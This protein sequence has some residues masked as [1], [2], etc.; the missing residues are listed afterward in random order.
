MNKKESFRTKTKNASANLTSKSRRDREN[1]AGTQ[2][3]SR[4]VSDAGFVTFSLPGCSR[5][6]MV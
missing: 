6:R 3:E 5:Q 4:A 1:R 2:M